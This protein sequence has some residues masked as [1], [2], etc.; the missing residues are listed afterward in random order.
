M[1]SNSL[2]AKLIGIY[3]SNISLLIFKPTL[4]V[5]IIFLIVI[6]SLVTTLVSTLLSL[7]HQRQH[8]IESAQSATSALSSAI[9]ANLRH[10]MLTVDREMIADSVQAVVA[11]ESVEALRILND[12]GIVRVSSV[13]SEV[14][15]QYT[16]T[17]AVCQS[18]HVESNTPR[19]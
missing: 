16:R 11:E 15:T 4:K 17:E 5:R 7:N 3:E 6:I 14:G 13:E 12:Q 2:V 8:L 19:R 10:A 9:E 1:V 18:C